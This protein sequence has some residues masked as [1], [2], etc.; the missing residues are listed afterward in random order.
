MRWVSQADPNDRKYRCEQARGTISI[1]RGSGLT[2]LR[3]VL[4][5]DTYYDVCNYY[6]YY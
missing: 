5:C 3:H 1:G 2:F 4:C 6:Y